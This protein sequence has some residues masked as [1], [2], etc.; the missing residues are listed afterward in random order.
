M[1]SNNML[2]ESV[3][4]IQTNIQ[5]P[6]SHLRSDVVKGAVGRDGKFM[7]RVSYWVPPLLSVL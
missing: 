3:K 4:N 5:F 2:S 6:P 7:L 1:Q